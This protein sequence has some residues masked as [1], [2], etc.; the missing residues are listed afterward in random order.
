MLMKLAEVVLTASPAEHKA[1]RVVL[2]IVF[3]IFFFWLMDEA[4][5]A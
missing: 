2:G 1:A 3:M 4:L 5:L